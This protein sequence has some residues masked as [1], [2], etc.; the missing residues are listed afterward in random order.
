M[1]PGDL[2]YVA[3]E[4]ELMALD[5]N[6]FPAASRKVFGLKGQKVQLARAL[7]CL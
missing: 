1:V 5:R 7:R 2:A 6:R 4:A 3:T